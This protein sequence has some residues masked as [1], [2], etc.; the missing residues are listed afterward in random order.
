MTLWFVGLGISGSGSVPAQ[1]ADVLKSSDVTYL[2]TFTSPAADIDHIRTIV[3]NLK[4][5]KRWMVEDGREIL[6]NAAKGTVALAVYGDPLVA[7][8]H[9]E[10]RVRAANRG[11]PTR[12][13]H[14]SSAITSMIGECG[15]HHYKAGRVATIMSEDESLSTPYYITYRNAVAGAHTV[16]LLEY[17]E[18][19]GFFLDPAKALRMLQQAESGQ[20]RGAFTGETYVVVA[21]RIGSPDQEIVAGMMSGMVQRDFGAPPHSVIVPGRLHFTERDALASLATCLDEPPPE[22]HQTKS[23]PAQMMERYVPMVRETMDGLPGGGAAQRHILDNARRYVQDAIRAL[24]DGQ[25]EVAVLSIGY[26]DGLVDALRMINGM[27]P[28][29]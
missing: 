19:R 28:N 18:D 4:V 27:D 2:E 13:I 22:T 12:V 25:D 15:L 9:N 23:I 16:L 24:E 21:S 11:I 29:M 6:D 17:D 26:A 14:A 3:G 20:N 5:A 7:T 8:T 1:A 10:L